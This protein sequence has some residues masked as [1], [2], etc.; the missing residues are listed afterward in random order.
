M[1]PSTLP[2]ALGSLAGA[3]WPAIPERPTR[4]AVSAPATKIALKA[5]VTELRVK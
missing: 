1:L 2:F 3:G 4:L 5:P